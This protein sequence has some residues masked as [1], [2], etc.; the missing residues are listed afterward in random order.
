MQGLEPSQNPN[1]DLNPI[2]IIHPVSGLNEV[3]VLYASV[4]KEFSERPSDR[5]EIDL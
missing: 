4:Q 5:Q 2:R 1:W 3:Q